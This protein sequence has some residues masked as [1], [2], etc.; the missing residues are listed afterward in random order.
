MVAG[1][2]QAERCSSAVGGELEVVNKS[3]IWFFV[4]AVDVGSRCRKTHG[5]TEFLAGEGLTRIA[6]CAK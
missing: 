4:V 1:E 6:K 5:M 3:I 2:G